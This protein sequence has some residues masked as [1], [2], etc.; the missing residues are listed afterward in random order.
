M[1]EG[2]DNRP[3]FRMADDECRVLA[4]QSLGCDQHPYAVKQFGCQSKPDFNASNLGPRRRRH[5][6]QR[7]C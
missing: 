3:S 2:R 5:L 6:A 7:I 1:G 4:A